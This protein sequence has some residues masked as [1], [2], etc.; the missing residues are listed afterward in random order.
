MTVRADDSPDQPSE[1]ATTAN[2]INVEFTWSAP[3]SENG[4]PITEYKLVI[5]TKTGELQE[6]LNCLTEQPRFS[7][8]VSFEKLTQ[9]PFNLIQGNEVRA[10]V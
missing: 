8:L 2:G 3:S 7:C 1:V 5:E 4:S 9:D 6:E 10:Q